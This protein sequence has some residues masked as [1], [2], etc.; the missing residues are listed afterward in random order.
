MT[1]DNVPRCLVVLDLGLLVLA[2]LF[3]C[4]GWWQGAAVC[5]AISVAMA[6]ALR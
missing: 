5:V 4:S 3:A 6:C 1:D 2:V